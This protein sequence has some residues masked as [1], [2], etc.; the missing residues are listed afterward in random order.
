[1]RKIQLKDA[2]ARLSTF[3][4]DAV[5]VAEIEDG[6]AKSIRRVLRAKANVYANGWMRWCIYT[7]RESC[8]STWVRSES[9]EHYPIKHEAKATR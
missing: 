5:T 1:M 4:D 9:R 3:I 8:R 7:V 2:K 6:I